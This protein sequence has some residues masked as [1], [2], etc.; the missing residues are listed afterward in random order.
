MP[1][2]KIK[3]NPQRDYYAA[4]G[5]A[6]NVSP[7]DLRQAYRH[8]V[9]EAH[10]DLHPDRAE[11]ATEQ[12]QLINEAY[13]VLRDPVQRQD[14]NRLRWLHIPAQARPKAEA[15]R[16]PYEA[17]G[18]DANRPWWEQVVNYTPSNG[19]Y[20]TEPPV[21]QTKTAH[22]AVKTWNTV[23]GLWSTPYSG[24]L[25]MLSIALAI[26]IAVILYALTN[27]SSSE[28]KT[29]AISAPP[30]QT[31]TPEPLYPTCDGSNGVTILNLTDYSLFD[32]NYPMISI[33]GTIEQ[34]NLQNYRIQLAYWGV[35]M[36]VHPGAPIWESVYEPPDAQTV[37][38]GA[39]TEA[40]PLGV[41]DLTGRRDGFYIIRVQA[42]TTPPVEP[43]DIVIEYD[44][45]N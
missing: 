29:A 15:Y 33:M 7:D 36:A 38:L 34:R 8:A 25:M 37:P 19:V 9:R 21:P 42:L 30:T 35:N 12:L 18:Y 2:G 17:P 16:S 10:P 27:P 45:L 6:D 4:L 26:N 39:I 24:L 44:D 22:P 28:D 14:Y 32:R 31:A 1:R 5:V 43:C 40:K 11:W 3:Y 20:A 23:I 41:I 13:N